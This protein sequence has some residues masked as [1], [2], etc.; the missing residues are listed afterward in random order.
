MNIIKVVKNT[1]ITT[2]IGVTLLLWSGCGGVDEA[3]MAELNNL[4]DEVNSLESEAN[5]LKEER[6]TLER[7]IA[8]KNAK[9]QQCEKDKEETRANLNKLPTSTGNTGM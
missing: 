4:R 3:M 5:S 9:L 6:S 7:E 2:V 8:D 1:M